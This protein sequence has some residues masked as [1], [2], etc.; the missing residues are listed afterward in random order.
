MNTNSETRIR[1]IGILSTLALLSAFAGSALGQNTYGTL[2]GR[3]TDAQ[4]AVIPGAMVT[5]TNQST[6]IARSVQTGATGDYSVLNLLPGTYEVSV[7]MD[8]FKKA[9]IESIA[10]R[11]NESVR[12]DVALQ[13]GEVVE[14]IEVSSTVAPLLETTR[15][16]LGTVVA[17]EE[18]RGASVERPR[19]DPADDAA[20]RRCAGRER[21]RVLHHRRP[22]SRRHGEPQRPEQL[23]P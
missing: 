9:L 10:L 21:R 4:D 11:V 2:V 19:H 3:V 15:S 8:G 20:A 18:S 16:T 7:E 6:N 13:V 1:W 22:D 17:N 5:A 14:T 12:V 23:H